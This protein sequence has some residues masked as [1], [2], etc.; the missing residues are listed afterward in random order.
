MRRI[1]FQIILLILCVNSEFVHSDE[2]I[3]KNNLM[4]FDIFIE[5]EFLSHKIRTFRDQ[6][7]ILG[8]L[9]SKNNEYHINLELIK[10]NESSQNYLPL[11]TVKKYYNEIKISVARGLT[12]NIN[13]N[14]LEIENVSKL[15][16]TDTLINLIAR[17]ITFSKFDNIISDNFIKKINLTLIGFDYCERSEILKNMET[18]FPNF[19]HVEIIS[20]NL[21]KSK[22]K[23]YTKTT[24]YKIQS[25]SSQL[26][27]SYGFNSKEFF[28]KVIKNNVVLK[29]S[30]KKQ[31]IGSCS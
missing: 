3:K 4:R 23:Y 11:L 17:N 8:I 9:D 14:V 2:I 22:Y 26:M 29:K 10:K 19:F 20:S 21:S 5:K 30:K 25:W 28:I 16:V 12:F 27:F 13:D 6:N 24:I 7:N 1:F 31:K 15:L 18:Q